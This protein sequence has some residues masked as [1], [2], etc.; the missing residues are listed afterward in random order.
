MSVVPE[1]GSPTTNTGTSLSS[2]P[3]WTLAKNSGVETPISRGD[4]RLV[5]LDVVLLAALPPLDQLQGVAA[6]EVPGGLGIFAPGIVHLH[7]PK[8]SKSRWASVVAASSSRR[9]L[10]RDVLVREPA[11]QDLRQLVVA[12]GE[13]GVLPQGPPERPLPPRR[14]RPSPPRRSPG[15]RRPRRSRAAMLGPSASRPGPRR[16]GPGPSRPHPG[17]SAVRRSRASAPM[18]AASRPGPRRPCPAPSGRWP[19]C[20]RLRR[21]RASTATPG[22]RRPRPGPAFLAP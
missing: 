8:C 9:R 22:G 7:R 10:G 19:A 3:P 1:R 11:A 17:C 6:V 18:P 15:C 5:L 16:A 4:E 14:N 13:A 20:Y 12:Q 21:S 2:P